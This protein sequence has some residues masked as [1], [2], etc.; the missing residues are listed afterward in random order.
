MNCKEKLGALKMSLG[1]PSGDGR[2]LDDETNL[3]GW[4]C[5]RII[6]DDRFWH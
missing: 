1:L 2:T 4:N 3:S 5:L 6:S